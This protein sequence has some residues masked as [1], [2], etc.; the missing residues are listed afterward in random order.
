[1]QLTD[2]GLT[3]GMWTDAYSQIGYLCVT[4]NYINNTLELTVRVLCTS[5]RDETLKKTAVM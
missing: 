3:L 4:L 2:F 5:G 1:M